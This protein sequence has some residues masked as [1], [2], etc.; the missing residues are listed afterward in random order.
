VKT[1]LWLLTV[2]NLQ[3]FLSDQD[4]KTTVKVI[5]SD[6]FTGIKNI[7]HTTPKPQTVAT[8]L[9]SGSTTVAQQTEAV[10]NNKTFASTDVTS[11]ESTESPVIILAAK[12][13][14]S[15][16][17]VM[18]DEITHAPAT[19]QAV[20][21]VLSDT[22]KT[23]NISLIQDL[24]EMV[25]P[26]TLHTEVHTHSPAHISTAAESGS[27]SDIQSHAIN[28]NEDDTYLT[29][30]KVVRERTISL[31]GSLKGTALTETNST[32]STTVVSNSKPIPSDINSAEGNAEQSGVLPNKF[33]E[34]F[35]NKTLPQKLK[36]ESSAASSQVHGHASLQMDAE[37]S[38]SSNTSKY[39]NVKVRRHAKTEESKGNNILKWVC[40]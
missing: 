31:E 1:C 15:V 14:E 22:N 6:I 29:S 32:A 26:T 9:A 33:A 23:W 20:T 39:E 37:M 24:E 7:F 18:P 4:G 13:T 10:Y 5:T 25:A 28:N 40:E 36:L 11:L 21:A 35:E 19:L 2:L 34:H 3:S 16:A 38:L 8:I 17:S 27:W 12:G 30:L